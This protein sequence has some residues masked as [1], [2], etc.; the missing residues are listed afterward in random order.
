[1][2]SPIESTSMRRFVCL[3][4]ISIASPTCAWWEDGHIT[5]SKIAE[6]NLRPEVRKNLEKLLGNISI[7]DPKICLFADNVRRNPDF[8]QYKDSGPWHYVNRPIGEEFS[9]KK[10]CLEGKCV[11][12]KL[13]EFRIVL[14]DK[15][16]KS[17]DRLEALI[18]I[19]H[20][21]EDMHQ[22]MHCANRYDKGGNDLKVRYPRATEGDRL[23]MHM[24]WDGKLVAD[25]MDGLVL[26]DFVV[27]LDESMKDEDRKKWKL[28]TPDE[29]AAEN[30]KI[31]AEYAYKAADGTAFAKT[32]VIDL[33]NAY[34]KRN[35]PI[36]RMQLQKAGLRLAEV[37]NECLQ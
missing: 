9:H 14:K 12:E 7:S 18:F 30:H 5:A 1:M 32:G 16:R 20:L 11:V 29:W 34:V 31:A 13:E 2:I 37:L 4:A 15:T 33:D 17:E 3:I 35:T 6:R 25:A 10:H 36:V 19:V 8:P 24:V 26:G 22:P 28:G 27:R 21:V 23:N